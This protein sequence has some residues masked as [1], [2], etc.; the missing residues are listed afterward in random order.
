MSQKQSL[1]PLPILIQEII[2]YYYHFTQWKDKM[3]TLIEEYREK[4]ITTDITYK[5]CDID[6]AAFICW[7]PSRFP[8][9]TSIRDMGVRY[10]GVFSNIYSFAKRKNSEYVD[11]EDI[12]RPP[13]TFTSSGCMCKHRLCLNPTECY[14]DY[15]DIP[16]PAIA[17]SNIT[18]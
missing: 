5:S 18:E 15:M 6:Q 8:Y 17:H 3:K 13:K 9:I 14:Y 2:S 4:L 10:N 12:Y 11:R 1:P 16:I 7:N